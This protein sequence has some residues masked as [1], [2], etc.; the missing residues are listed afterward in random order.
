MWATTKNGCEM[1][2]WGWRPGLLRPAVGGAARPEFLVCL[3]EEGTINP[4]GK[5]GQESLAGVSLTEPLKSTT[6]KEFSVTLW[7][8]LWPWSLIIFDWEL[9]FQGHR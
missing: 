9:E 2:G 6:L 8:L 7:Q 5:V 1:R 3:W 4:G